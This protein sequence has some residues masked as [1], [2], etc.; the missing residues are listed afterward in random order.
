MYIYDISRNIIESH[1]YPGD[2]DTKVKI[3]ESIEDG[4]N[5]NLS[6]FEMCSHTGTHVDAP[7]HFDPDGKK[8]GDIRSAVFYGKCSVVTIDDILT[9]EQMEKILPY[10]KSRILFRSN[11]NGHIM[12]S[13]AEVIA[14]SNVV[15]VGIDSNSIALPHEECKTHRTLALAD[16]AIIENL[17]LTDIHDG[18]DYTLCAFPIRLDS[19]E[20][21]PCRAILLEQEKG[22]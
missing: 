15:L 6:S 9:G 21:A 10:C 11:G 1:P 17:D 13:A 20:A 2:P 4:D 7:Y 3:F 19:L 22:F 14:D 8:I 5:C 16:V 12:L 18:N